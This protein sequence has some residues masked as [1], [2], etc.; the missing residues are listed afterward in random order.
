MHMYWVQ[1]LQGLLAHSH[2]YDGY[3]RLRAVVS[4]YSLYYFLLM[5]LTQIVSSTTAD[6]L[7]IC[8]T[9]TVF[10]IGF[11]MLTRSLGRSGQLMGLFGFPLA[12]GWC[13]GMG[14]LSYMLCL[15]FGLVALALWFRYVR[16]ATGAG[17]ALAFLAVLG[18]MAITHPIPLLLVLAT[19]YLDLLS[20]L[21]GNGRWKRWSSTDS[22]ALATL[23]V[24]SLTALYVL[25]FADP[26]RIR[27]R[28]TGL[29][30]SLAK[31][32]LRLLSLHSLSLFRGS[33]PLTVLYTTGLYLMFFGALWMA[34]RSWRRKENRSH[35]L[36]LFLGIALLL[37]V[38][39]PLFPEQMNGGKYFAD[40]LMPV[41]WVAALAAGS[42]L[43]LPSAKATGGIAAFAMLMFVLLLLQGEQYV[44][45]AARASA[46]ME[47]M[48]VPA[49][50]ALAGIVVN[51]SHG[52]VKNG[53]TTTPQYWQGTRYV[54]REH[55]IMLNTPWLS[56]S[57]LPLADGPEQMTRR[58]PTEVL[59]DPKWQMTMLPEI[60]EDRAKAHQTP[61]G[62]VAFFYGISRSE[63]ATF[64][65]SLDAAS[66]GPWTCEDSSRVMVCRPAARH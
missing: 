50:G 54:R 23:A 27:V 55:A 35:D 60:T 63:A 19:A 65:A 22:R 21:A 37:L 30:L 41:V 6:K 49:P 39:L 28:D 9:V 20:R 31:Q 18:L 56:E 64:R 7:V 46:Q 5:L 66:G 43:R 45:P 10:C 51:G 36:M 15:G 48:D 16:N 24:G 25:H 17:S 3:Y 40:R 34:L 12:V 32:T 62:F 33:R 57:I 61:A 29:H 38:A 26:N 2:T 4:P 14:F 53:L 11:R 44:R 59:D 13:L 58:L 1:V 8:L 47:T 42:C 52:Q